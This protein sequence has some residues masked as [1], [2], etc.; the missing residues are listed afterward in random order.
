MRG[1][2]CKDGSWGHCRG[3]RF[4]SW[5]GL[6]LGGNGDGKSQGFK[7]LVMILSGCKALQDSYKW[8]RCQQQ[9]K[10]P[11][12]SFLACI[13]TCQHISTHQEAFPPSLPSPPPTRN[14]NVGT[15][16]LARL[17]H[18]CNC[19]T[20]WAQSAPKPPAAPESGRRAGGAREILRCEPL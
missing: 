13:R 4:G 14:G 15:P 6:R 17:G 5:C 16:G 18:Y 9:S 11:A 1:V 2:H 7:R 3:Q 12:A 8:L 10:V 20:L 19:D